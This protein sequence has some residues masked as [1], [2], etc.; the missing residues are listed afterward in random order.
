MLVISTEL[1]DQGLVAPEV[2]LLSIEF[3][4]D[5]SGARCDGFMSPSPASPYMAPLACP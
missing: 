3:S 2:S 4:A 5:Y 1:A